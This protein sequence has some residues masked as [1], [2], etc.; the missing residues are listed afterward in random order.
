MLDLF[1]ITMEF[2]HFTTLSYTLCQ[3]LEGGMG[4]KVIAEKTGI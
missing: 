1:K 4:K 2:K 3:A